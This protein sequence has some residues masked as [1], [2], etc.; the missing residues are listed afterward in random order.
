MPVSLWKSI[1]GQTSQ[2]YG[3]R[4]PDLYLPPAER[5]ARDILARNTDTGHWQQDGSWSWSNFGARKPLRGGP[6][7]VA[8]LPDDTRA[9]AASTTS[10]ISGYRLEP[11]SQAASTLVERPGLSA[12]RL[13][14]SGASVRSY[15]SR[16]LYSESS[17]VWSRQQDGADAGSLSP[18]KPKKSLKKKKS[19]SSWNPSAPSRKYADAAAAG[20][21]LPPT[22]P[23][24]IT[25]SHHSAAPDPSYT[26][27]RAVEE[28]APSSYDASID[29]SRDDAARDKSAGKKAAR[30]RMTSI[31]ED[32]EEDAVR[33]LVS[34]SETHLRSC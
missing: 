2:R 4:A 14:A 29:A 20:S 3:D 21:S 34:F 26:D 9:D 7:S 16:S 25:S 5:R 30:L 15:D 32:Q 17:S 10:R 22:R 24:S 12:R 31:V 6:G 18:R 28:Q 13:S 11:A 19:A 23:A 1:T 27:S 33:S 8:G